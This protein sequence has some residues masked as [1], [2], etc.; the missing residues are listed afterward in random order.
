MSVQTVAS[1][2][3]AMRA[4]EVPEHIVDQYQLVD[5]LESRESNARPMNGERDLGSPVWILVRRVPA[6]VPSTPLRQIDASC[7]REPRILLPDH[8]RNA[9]CQRSP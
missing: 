1:V 5:S 4:Q 6:G 2:G 7:V 3:R 8:G 9:P